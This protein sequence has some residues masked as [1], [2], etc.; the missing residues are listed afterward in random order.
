MHSEQEGKAVGLFAGVGGIEWG[1]HEAGVRPQMLCENYEPAQRVLAKRF[2]RTPIEPDV[3]KLESLPDPFILA[4]GFPCQDLSQ[5]GRTAGI[6]GA[7]SSLIG[8]VF[9]LLR[10]SNPR[11]LLIE[12]VSFMLH[13]NRGDAMWF[14]IESLEELGFAWAYR[15]VDSM[16]FGLPQRRQRVLLL[17]SRTEDPRPILFGD[18]AGEPITFDGEADAYGFYWTEGT[19]GL[20]WAENAIPT[21]KGGS[22]IGIPSPPAIWFTETDDLVVPDIVGAERLQGFPDDW[23]APADQCSVKGARWKLVGNAV[24]VPVAAWIG[25]RL[26]SG[27]AD[28]WSDVRWK[29]GAWPRAAWGRQNDHIRKVD[30][31][32]WPINR[33]RPKL[34][35][36][37]RG[38]S[39][40]LSVRAAEGFLN[41]A[42]SGN[43]RPRADFLNGVANYIRRMKSSSEMVA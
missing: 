43:L 34:G 32:A 30:R 12:N 15:V 22:T 41:R 21:L 39:R 23:T 20:G 17:A 19:N 40:P 27:S 25:S 11:W 8:S 3:T 31:S 24:S 33:K 5:A 28:K 4:A 29:G 26:S 13:L 37:L 36:L 14:L 1:L 42:I 7:Q 6:E 16:A 9:K 10:R 35:T 2:K 38:H 18:E